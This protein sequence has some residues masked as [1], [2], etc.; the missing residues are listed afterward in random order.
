MK[1]LLISFTLFLVATATNSFAGDKNI[2][3]TVSTS[4]AKHFTT[5]KNASWSQVG[6]LYEVQFEQDKQVYYGFYNEEGDLVV[7]SRHI[8]PDMLEPKLQNNLK[9]YFADG[10]WVTDLFE[11]KSENNISYFL[12]INNADRQLE[13]KS[14]DNGK[15]NVFSK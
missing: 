2:P 11:I 9:K 14:T 6:I 7:L 10:Y 1:L 3:G 8:S 4:F 13:L 12:I 5:A 15:W